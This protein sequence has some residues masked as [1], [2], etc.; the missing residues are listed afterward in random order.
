MVRR[1]S[2]AEYILARVYVFRE[3]LLKIVSNGVHDILVVGSDILADR[4]IQ[5]G[6][7]ELHAQHFV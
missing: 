7:W 5:G 6:D 2:H 1:D 4:Q 3:G